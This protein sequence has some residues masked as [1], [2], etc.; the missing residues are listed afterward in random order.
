[1][2][3]LSGDFRQMLPVNPRLTG[4]DNACLKSSNLGGET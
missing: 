3:L 1:M 4:I 2:I